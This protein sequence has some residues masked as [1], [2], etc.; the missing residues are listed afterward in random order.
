VTWG[1]GNVKP[2]ASA[3][4][5]QERNATSSSSDCEVHCLD[6]AAELYVLKQDVAKCQ[7]FEHPDTARSVRKIE[8]AKMA[9]RLKKLLSLIDGSLKKWRR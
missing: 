7:K 5:T 2:G 8:G 6:V 3:S 9:H 1:S 4:V